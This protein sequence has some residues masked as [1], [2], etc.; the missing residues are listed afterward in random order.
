MGI[1][2]DKGYLRGWWE[3]G[4]RSSGRKVEVLASKMLVVIITTISGPLSFWPS[5]LL[6]MS[7]NKLRCRFH[8]YHFTD[9]ETKAQVGGGVL[10]VT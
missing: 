1:D 4:G 10:K 7:H 2:C 6:L 3:R 9:G 5:A 8:D